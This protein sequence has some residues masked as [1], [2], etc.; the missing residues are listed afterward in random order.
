MV[1]IIIYSTFRILYRKSTQK[2]CTIGFRNIKN[3]SNNYVFTFI[4]KI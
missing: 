2:T 1:H 3:I 4:N